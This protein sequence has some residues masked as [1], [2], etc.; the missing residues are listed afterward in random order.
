LFKYIKVPADMGIV[1]IKLIINLLKVA[2]KLTNCMKQSPR[3]AD[4]RSAGQEIPHFL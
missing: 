4:S 2:T 1:V 3:E